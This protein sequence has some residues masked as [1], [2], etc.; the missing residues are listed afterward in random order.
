MGLLLAFAV[1]LSSVSGLSLGAVAAEAAI[2][3]TDLGAM[4]AKILSDTNAYRAAAGQ[5]PLQMTSGLNNQAQNWSSSQADNKTMAHDP[6]YVSKLPGVYL[7]SG[8]NVGFGSEYTQI[9]A[10]WYSSPGHRANLLGQYNEIGIGVAYDENNEPYYTQYFGNNPSVQTVPW[11]PRDVAASPGA[12]GEANV[13]FAAH[14]N[15]GNSPITGYVITASPTNGQAPT[16]F[17]V[18]T[19]GSHKITGLAGGLTYNINVKAVNAIGQS[20]PSAFVQVLVIG[21]PSVQVTSMDT[22]P[23]SVVINW[24]AKENGSAITGY[25]FVFNGGT[26]VNLP[27]GTVSQS[28]ANLKP[29]TNYNGTIVAI[30]GVGESQAVPYSFAT[31]AVAPDAPPAPNA[32][33]VDKTN[34]AIKWNKPSYDGGAAITAYEIVVTESGVN[35]VVIPVAGNVLSY[36]FANAVRGK[37]YTVG[38]RAINSAGASST[39]DVVINVPYT[40]PDAVT[41]LVS[42]LT[43]ERTITANWVASFD[44]GGFPEL[45]YIVTINKVAA[46]GDITEFAVENTT[47]TTVTF[48]DLDPK[49]N[50][51]VAVEANNTFHTSA[52]TFSN[53]VNVPAV[54]TVSSPV[55]NLVYSNVTGDSVDL[56]WD[57]PVDNGGT[58]ITGYRIEI[59][60]NDTDDVQTYNVNA[61]TTSYKVVSLDRFTNYTVRVS[62]INAKGA[63]DPFLATFNTLADAPSAPTLVDASFNTNTASPFAPVWVI[64]NPEDDGGDKEISFNVTVSNSNGTESF[65]IPMDKNNQVTVL[66]NPSAISFLQAGDEFNVSVTAVNSGGASESIEN[67]FTGPVGA[68]AVTGIVTNFNEDLS[69][70]TVNWNAPADAGTFGQVYGYSVK[71]SNA[72]NPDMVYLETSVNNRNV[73]LNTPYGKV[74]KIEVSPLT[75]DTASFI[76]TKAEITTE[77]MPVVPPGL[78]TNVTLNSAAPGS[79]TVT[80]EAPVN[81]GGSPLNENAVVDI[82]DNSNPAE[83]VVIKTVEADVYEGTHTFT[84]LRGGTEIIAQVRVFNSA[85]TSGSAYS[86]EATVGAT[87]PEAPTTVD[88]KL[89]ENVD[90]TVTA[91]LESGYNGGSAITGYEFVLTAD[92]FSQTKVS[93]NKNATWTNV[94]RGKEYVVTASVINAIGKSEVTSSNG[95]T[96]PAVAPA[97]PKLTLKELTS[98]SATVSGVVSDNGGATLTGIEYSYEDGVWIDAESFDS[99]TGVFEIRAQNLDGLEE[100]TFTVRAVNKVGNS[101]TSTLNFTVPSKAPEGVNVTSSTVNGRSLFITWETVGDLNEKETAGLTYRAS[102][103]N[104]SDELIESITTKQSATSFVV[105]PGVNGYSV[106]SVSTDGGVTFDLVSSPR[107]FSIA[108]EAP[109]APINITQT[110]S[111]SVTT[112]FVWEAPSFNGGS[113]ITGY[114]FVLRQGDIVVHEV[115]TVEPKITGLNLA[116]G[117]TYDVEVRAINIVGAGSALTNTFVT[118]TTPPSGVE[119]IVTTGTDNGVVFK[120]DAPEDDGGVAITGYEYTLRNVKTSEIVTSG[121]LDAST[122]E[123][124]EIEINVGNVNFEFSVTARNSNGLGVTEK[125][126]YRSPV[127]APAAAP[128]LTNA[129]F[130]ADNS[131]L[132][133]TWTPSVNDGGATDEFMVTI[134]GENVSH[135]E[136]VPAGNV[137]PTTVTVKNVDFENNKAYS[138]SIQSK[139]TKGVS[140][141]SEKLEVKSNILA[142]VAGDFDVKVEENILTVTPKETTNDGGESVVYTLDVEGQTPA[143]VIPGIAVNYVVEY[144]QTYNVTLTTANSAGQN[145]S[146]EKVT[147]PATNPGVPSVV[148]TVDKATNDTTVTATAPTFNGGAEIVSYNFEIVQ[149]GNVVDTIVSEESVI[150]IKGS[151]LKANQNY[152]V[153]VWVENAAEL[154]SPKTVTAFNTNIIAPGVPTNVNVKTVDANNVKVT[155][156]A[157]AFDGG[158]I[159]NLTLTVDVYESGTNVLVNSS[160]RKVDVKQ[161][162]T[163][164]VTGLKHATSYYA[165]VYA[166]NSVATSPKV[167]SDAVKTDGIAPQVATSVT[168]EITGETSA[169]VS[170]KAPEDNGGSDITSYRVVASTISG[171][172]FATENAKSTSLEFKGLARGET[173]EFSVVAV[174]AFGESNKV[175]A[176][177]KATTAPKEMVTPLPEA[178]F[179]ET[180][181]TVEVLNAAINGKTLTVTLEDAN[182]FDWYAGFAY[183]E[184]Q[185][186]GWS[187]VKNGQLTYSIANVPAGNHTF[188]LYNTDGVLVG[189]FDFVVQEAGNG[190][191]GDGTDNTATGGGSDDKTT[192]K[193]DIAVKR[194]DGNDLTIPIVL[195]GTGML[196]L[197]A[198]AVILMRRRKIEA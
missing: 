14:P 73:T 117:K 51:V 9:T 105:S 187:F 59:T 67:T 118:G 44:N 154:T 101:E 62:A 170:W 146:S 166:N 65:D 174:N 198:G 142:P 180:K 171:E 60:N 77:A 86:N 20:A 57:A 103:Y 156:I 3:P 178:L 141:Q 56:N 90:T 192:S 121:S 153:N 126:N 172:V 167:V 5:P 114:E 162:V 168:A 106:V 83:T 195:S 70:T 95:V 22:T 48:S 177:G 148:V 169:V 40:A 165:S 39:S 43:D 197:L 130:N 119:N 157:P 84:G 186:L 136:T 128:V 196:L 27:A 98:R 26:P 109:E 133:V 2:T 58:A 69:R 129:K 93:T 181:D 28:F 97:K 33:V 46:N 32:T 99:A 68:S 1:V 42:S 35:P 63:S 81:D 24:S 176:E 149:N 41:G 61:N 111:N 94:P 104:D 50:Y 74:L 183:S 150:V 82:L 163:V 72:N 4:R 147:V 16:T 87:V 175:I 100:Y 155:A 188:A 125:V 139:N 45:N 107:E 158:D 191:S 71:I 144:G 47:A 102:I 85:G 78:A 120:W 116:K 31:P 80:W 38:V 189:T 37:D 30:N 185:A 21:V 91:T 184:P 112:G 8:E 193:N 179:N 53:I 11:A 134:T 182:E 79:A 92:G 54:P 110:V 12:S 151:G 13:S 143:V 75:H 152:S 19:A 25:R 113:A 145:S 29:G 123:T 194:T 164:D 18:P 122:L 132:N 96:V 160:T 36:N 10:A 135:V 34:I 23:Y 140:P 76:G 159:E 7:N 64:G 66:E 131:E 137:I 124:P 190:G 88:A 138:V 6:N 49:A 89:D 173:Y 108:P 15:T 55:E 161:E 52:K 17:N 127:L 115:T